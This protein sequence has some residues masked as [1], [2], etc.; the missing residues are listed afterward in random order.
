MEVPLGFTDSFPRDICLDGELWAGYD[1]FSKLS[2]ILRT[3]SNLQISSPDEKY[4]AWKEVQYCVFDAPMHPG[5]YFERH[6][7]A[8]ASLSGPNISLIPIVKCLG[9]DHMQTILHEISH[10]RGEGLMLYNPSAK[11]TSGRTNHILKV[12]PSLEADVR[13]ISKN[14]NSYSFLCEQ[15]NGVKCIVKCSGW[16]YMYPPSPGTLLTVKHNGIFKTSQK[17]KYPY[18]IRTHLNESEQHEISNESSIL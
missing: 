6:S 15:K 14:P 18:L 12:K 3:T 2:S 11:Y 7:F 4:E 1:G 10:K 16:D 13:F 9:L 5:N 17:L 8:S